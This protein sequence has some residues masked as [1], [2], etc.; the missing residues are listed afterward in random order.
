MGGHHHKHLAETPAI[1]SDAD[2]TSPGSY[3]SPL[4]EWKA[5]Y[6]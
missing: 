1:E 5:P 6:Q 2:S 4:P 3:T